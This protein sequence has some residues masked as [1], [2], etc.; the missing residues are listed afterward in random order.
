MFEKGKI[1]V[2]KSHGICTIADILQIGGL[3]YYKIIPSIDKTMSIFVPVNKE[4]ELL[5]EVLTEKQADDIVEY[6]RQ[7]DD[8]VID[9]SKE[10]RDSF[11]KK[12]SS[13]DLKEIAYMCNKLYQLKQIK[14]DTN[15]KFCLTDNSIFEKASKLLFDELAVAYNIKRDEIV[16]FVVNKLKKGTSNC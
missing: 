4:N 6:M 16:P 12:L 2:H 15:S 5:R 9:D 11:H 13:G 1:I 7:I 8:T 14:M 10:R 3:N